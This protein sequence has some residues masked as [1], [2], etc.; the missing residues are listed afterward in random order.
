MKKEN[1][2]NVNPFIAKFRDNKLYL[3]SFII[4]LCVLSYLI[5]FIMEHSDG[6]ITKRNKKQLEIIENIK[7]AKKANDGY[8]THNV[9]LNK[10]VDIGTCTIDSYSY[11]FEVKEGKFTRYFS[12]NCLGVIKLGEETNI[13]VV[14][15]SF[16][17][18]NITYNKDASITSL[19]ESNN[20]SVS[21]YFYTDSIVMLSDVDLV[22]I[23]NNT[24][25]YI[26]SEN[27]INDGGNLSKRYYE[28]ENEDTFNFIVFYNKEEVPCY[29]DLSSINGKDKLYDIYQIHY[30]KA[31]GKFDSP[32]L[33]VSRINEDYCSNYENDIDI[34]KQ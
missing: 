8:Y 25:S 23:N 9:T 27:Y 17:T 28:S 20:S 11:I 2:K 1:K 30:N 19:I 34:L 16:T 31:L 33:M 13:N 21:L 7:K 3:I 18:N 5:F 29:N 14:D 26:N 32:K 22:L 10:K 24:V 6:I 15:Y 4:T 12:N